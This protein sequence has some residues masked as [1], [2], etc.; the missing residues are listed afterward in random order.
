MMGKGVAARGYKTSVI[1]VVPYGAVKDV[2]GNI[3]PI[4]LLD[5]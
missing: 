4:L 2:A 5:I 1:G 3:D